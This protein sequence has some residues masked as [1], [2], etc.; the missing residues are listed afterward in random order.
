V[1]GDDDDAV[2]LV[3]YAPGRVGEDPVGKDPLK[4]LCAEVLSL[5]LILVPL[6]EVVCA[7]VFAVR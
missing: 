1:F 6:V 5:V 4:D 2:V 3:R 7:Q